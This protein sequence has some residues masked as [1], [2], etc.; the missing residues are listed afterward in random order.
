MGVE[1]DGILDKYRINGSALQEGIF[2][3]HLNMHKLRDVVKR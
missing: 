2:V 3:E 1:V